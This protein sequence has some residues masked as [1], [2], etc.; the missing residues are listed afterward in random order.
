MERKGLLAR[1]KR[2]LID[3]RTIALSKVVNRKTLKRVYWKYKCVVP[4]EV[5]DELGWRDV[6]SLS[7]HL[8]RDMLVLRGIGGV[9]TGTGAI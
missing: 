1:N 2:S 9:S 8:H 5:I 7:Y 4:L 3:E 6:R